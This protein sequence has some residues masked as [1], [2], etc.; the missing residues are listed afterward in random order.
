[1]VSEG[2]STLLDCSNI[3]HETKPFISHIK[4]I[5][6]GNHYEF[7]INQKGSLINGQ[8]FKKGKRGTAS[9][10]DQKENRK[11]SAIRAR[12][13]FRRK[14]NAN[15]NQNSKFLTLTIDDNQPFNIRDFNECNIYF[16]LFIK[17]LRYRYP[18]FK[19]ARGAEF[20][21]KNRNGVIHYHL[22][23]DT[24]FILQEELQEIWG[25]GYIWINKIKHVDNVGLYISKYFLKNSNDKRLAGKKSYTFSKNCDVPTV[26]Q[27]KQAEALFK[28]FKDTPPQFQN[29][30]KSDYLGFISYI[31]Y[32]LNKIPLNLSK[33]DNRKS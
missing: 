1:M 13:D 32:N 22:I 4:A 12:N 23:I 7:Y 11:K 18:S 28:K 17:R 19:Y 29:Q 27:G 30:Y 9:E 21:D 3:S 33:D 5:Q 20:Q 8:K 15:F 2:V 10:E 14:I 31:H 25:H 16:D 6:S 24:N 26:Y